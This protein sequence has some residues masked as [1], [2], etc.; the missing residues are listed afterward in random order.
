MEIKT[1]Q[2]TVA[3]EINELIQ[4]WKEPQGFLNPG[5][6]SDGYHTFDEL[7]EHRI[8]LYIALLQQLDN[9]GFARPWMTKMHSNG[10][11]WEGWFILGVYDKEGEQIT[12][13]LPNI[14]WHACTEFALPITKAPKYDGHSSDDVLI[15][16]AGLINKNANPLRCGEK[17]EGI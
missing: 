3:E 6:I 2:Q 8:I 12:Y 1:P 10:E 5:M 9:T 11:V 13:H 14:Y 17:S 16:L 15:R 4:T 7:Y